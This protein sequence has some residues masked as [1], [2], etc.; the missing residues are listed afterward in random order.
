MLPEPLLELELAAC[1]FLH[2]LVECH[3]QFLC[4]VQYQ[5]STPSNLTETDE[6]VGAGLFRSSTGKGLQFWSL[7]LFR[8]WLPLPLRPA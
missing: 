2:S 8:C 3:P 4:L 5:Y 7:L 6:S 1:P